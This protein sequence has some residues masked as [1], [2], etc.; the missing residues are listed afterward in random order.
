MRPARIIGRWQQGH[1][2]VKTGRT[3]LQRV[4]GRGGSAPGARHALRRA[5][6]AEVSHGNEPF[7]EH[8]EEPASDE[9][10]RMDRLAPPLCVGAIFVAQEDTAAFI[11]AGE[12]TL[13]EGG[14]GDVGCEITQGA[15]A[16]SGGSAIGHPFLLPN[17]GVDPPMQF[18]VV[19]KQTLCKQTADASGERQ[20]R[21]EE[22]TSSPPPGSLAFGSRFAGSV[23][24]PARS[25]GSSLGGCTS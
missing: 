23:S 14:P 24:A 10:V 19:A 12:A 11:I 17:S 6:E 18:G 22:L 16:A 15:A 21:E 20:D 2:M 25:F 8:M 13:V 7:W 4:R 1:D 3:G 5:E 9:F